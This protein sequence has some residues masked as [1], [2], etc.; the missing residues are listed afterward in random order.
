MKL[1]YK[2]GNLMWSRGSQDVIQRDV[3][4]LTKRQLFALC[5][6]RVGHYPVCGWLRTACNF[7]KRFSSK[8]WENMLD[9]KIMSMTND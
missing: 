4:S 9:P 2:D 6:Q 8:N 1:S 3:D 7:I 5:G